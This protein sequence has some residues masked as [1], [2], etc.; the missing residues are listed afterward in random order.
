M[1]IIPLWQRIP[2]L[3][4][5]VIA[6]FVAALLGTGSW[7]A[8]VAMNLEQLHEEGGMK[9]NLTQQTALTDTG[10]IVSGRTVKNPGEQNEHDI[11]T[12]SLRN[13]MVKG[14]SHCSNWTS[15]MGASGVGHS[16]RMGTQNDPVVAASWNEAHE[17]DCG[18]TKTGG[19]AGRFY[20]FATN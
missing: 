8:L 16:D 15:D 3:P 19:G 9:N 2:A 1:T 17:D 5:A 20:C 10:K 6:G 11:L 4:R 18:N 12:G 14:T 13:G 7:A